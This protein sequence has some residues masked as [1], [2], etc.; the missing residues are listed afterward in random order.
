MIF[1][2]ATHFYFD[3][4]QEPDPEEYGNFWATRVIST[5]KLFKFNA[6][7]FYDNIDESMMGGALTKQTACG[8]GTV[9]CIPL[10][11]PE[12]LIGMCHDIVQNL[13]LQVSCQ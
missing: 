13:I 6:E 12:N 2:P 9:K 11:K 5:K 8:K 10:K 1:S 4:P 3:H 7:S